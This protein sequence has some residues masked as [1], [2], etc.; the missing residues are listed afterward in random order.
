VL[1]AKH[2]AALRKI[3]Q[4]LNIFAP[5]DLEKQKLETDGNSDSHQ[6]TSHALSLSSSSSQ[7]AS[8]L[9]LIYGIFYMYFEAYKKSVIKIHVEDS[10]DSI[11]GRHETSRH[12]GCAVVAS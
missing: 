9:S 7:H 1:L 5:F 11:L 3:S 4:N 12:K 2:A 8:Y 10:E 6:T